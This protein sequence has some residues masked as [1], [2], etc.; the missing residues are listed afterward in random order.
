MPKLTRALILAAAGLG[1]S[2]GLVT[3]PVAAANP[4]LPDCEQMGGSSVAGGQTTDC[5]SPGNVQIDATPQ[6]YPGE[7]EFW[8]YPGFG[9]F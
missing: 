6:E 2:A 7:D 3:A 8:G 4:L 5:A 9:F 1:V